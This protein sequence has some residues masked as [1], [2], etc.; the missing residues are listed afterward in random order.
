MLKK[1]ATCCMGFNSAAVGTDHSETRNYAS[2]M[3]PLGWLLFGAECLNG[4]I[5]NIGLD[6]FN[7]AAVNTLRQ[8]DYATLL[9][10]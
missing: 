3:Y 5:T 10:I 2:A 8:I 1:A 7:S 6:Q 9:N 4:L